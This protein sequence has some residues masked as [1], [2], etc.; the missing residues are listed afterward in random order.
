MYLKN[1]IVCGV[2]FHGSNKITKYCDLKCS[3]K[4]ELD[5]K[6]ARLKND[7]IF[8]EHRNKLERERRKR[9]GRDKT[10]HAIKE[11]ERYRKKHAILSDSD[12]KIAPRGSGTI[13]KHGYRQVQAK[14]HPNA[15]RTGYI[16]EHVLIMSSHLKRPLTNHERVHHKNGIRHDN[17]IENLELWSKSHP[18]GQRVEDKINWCKEF[19]EQ[20]GCSVIMTLK[21][22]ESNGS[23]DKP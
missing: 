19:L 5:K 14:G 8:R 2:E 18:Y 4:A 9:G 16:F 23:G 11:K 21:T 7:P 10:K 3:R 15:W 12:L 1:C 22:N 20:Y 17:R 6:R 13:N